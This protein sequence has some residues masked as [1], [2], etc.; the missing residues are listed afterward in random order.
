MLDDQMKQIHRQ[1]RTSQDKYTY[2]LLAVSASAIALSVQV[3]KGYILSVVLIPLGLAV[4]CWGISF[5]LGCKNVHYLNSTMYAN[6]EYLKVQSGVHPV[7]GR[8]TEYRQA[9]AE[10]IRDAMT[11]NS[12][13]ANVYGRWQFLLI[14]TGGG[15]YVVWHI[16]E[17]VVR[18]NAG[19]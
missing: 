10:G 7:I 9:A 16:C 2:F 19:N 3:T 8:T 4:F 13:A 6:L 18:T 17:M 1:L 11:K 12:E 15:W 5:Y 14:I